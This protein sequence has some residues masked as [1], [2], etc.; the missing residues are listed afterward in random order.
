MKHAYRFAI[1]LLLAV[2]LF[3]SCHN[4]G[5]VDKINELEERVSGL[6]AEIDNKDNDIEELETE[7]EDEKS[8]L[9]DIHAKADDIESCIEDSYYEDAMSELEDL[10][11]ITEY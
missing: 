11:D 9:D 6:E 4:Q 7:L 10:K 1:L 2:L 5:D 8:K 3:S